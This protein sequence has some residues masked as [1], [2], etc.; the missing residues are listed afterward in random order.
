MGCTLNLFLCAAL[1][2]L[3]GESFEVPGAAYGGGALLRLGEMNCPLLLSR[4]EVGSFSAIVSNPTNSGHHADV[5]FSTREFAQS[6]SASQQVLS[7]PPHSTTRATWSVSFGRPGSHFV[8]IEL[9]NDDPTSRSYEQKSFNYCGVAVLDV[10]GL[11][12]DIIVFLGVGALVLAVA[13][14]IYALRRS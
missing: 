12:A 3:F 14:A 6:L 7:V 9:T 4:Q 1:V 8:H 13:T 10:L 5:M 11:R 2:D